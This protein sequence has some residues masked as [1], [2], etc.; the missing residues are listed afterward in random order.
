[1]MHPLV[2]IPWIQGIWV[3]EMAM[4]LVST[5]PSTPLEHSTASEWCY[6]TTLAMS[7]AT[8]AVGTSSHTISRWRDARYRVQL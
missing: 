6:V 4:P 1:M 8:T 2:S 5:P 3:L 7:M